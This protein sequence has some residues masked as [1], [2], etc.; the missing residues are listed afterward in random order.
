MFSFH[1]IKPP[2]IT[3]TTYSSVI[4]SSHQ[5]RIFDSSQSWIIFLSFLPF[6]FI[7]NPRTIPVRVH[8]FLARSPFTSNSQNVIVREAVSNMQPKR[9]FYHWQNIAF[10]WAISIKGE[11]IRCHSSGFSIYIHQALYFLSSMEKYNIA[12]TILT[13]K[14]KF[15][16]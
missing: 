5:T 12:S 13:I 4:F 3:N 15:C 10:C 6:L 8:D 2:H 7:P 1:H 14:F 11:Q 16:F 9:L